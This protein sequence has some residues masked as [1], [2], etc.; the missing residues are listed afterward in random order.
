MSP[1]STAVKSVFVYT[2]SFEFGVRLALT[3]SRTAPPVMLA[4]EET[5]GE[6]VPLPDVDVGGA[7]TVVPITDQ[8]AQQVGVVAAGAGVTTVVTLVSRV[9][10]ELP[11]APLVWLVLPVDTL[12]VDAQ[13]ELAAAL[14]TPLRQLPGVPLVVQID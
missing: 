4:V 2:T 6:S 11:T 10:S 14:L 7:L 9:T 13:V 3:L 1:E 5:P 8:T 12:P